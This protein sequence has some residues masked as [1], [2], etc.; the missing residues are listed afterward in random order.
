MS[1]D[2][3]EELCPTQEPLCPGSCRPSPCLL[4]SNK[5]A[6]MR[7]DRRPTQNLPLA[8]CVTTWPLLPDPI[9]EED[10]PPC[11]QLYPWPAGSSQGRMAAP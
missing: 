9:D 11:S 4:Q 7:A 1:L 5:E 3:R 2:Q 8:R 10:P 6:G